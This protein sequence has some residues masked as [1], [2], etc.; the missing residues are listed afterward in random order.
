MSIRLTD[1]ALFCRSDS[2]TARLA[3]GYTPPP[4]ME[5]GERKR[6]RKSQSFKLVTDEG[7]L[8]NKTQDLARRASV[9]GRL[10]G[11]VCQR[12]RL[13]KQKRSRPKTMP[14]VWL[15]VSPPQVNASRCE[16]KNLSQC[17][18]H[19]GMETNCPKS[20]NMRHAAIAQTYNKLTS[21]SRNDRTF[22]FLLKLYALFALV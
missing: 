12:R 21:N 13:C 8:L 3:G 5:F 6:R 9:S 1:F 14:T 17:H 4:K 19:R 11:A 15:S 22:T 20:L 16:T 2:P 10:S 18:S 7:R